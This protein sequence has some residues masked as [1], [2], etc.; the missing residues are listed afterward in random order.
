MVSRGGE[1]LVQADFGGDAA[2]GVIEVW[3]ET[4]RD[5]ERE[6]KAREK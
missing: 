6:R 3:S 5:G 4:R 2:V 1:S